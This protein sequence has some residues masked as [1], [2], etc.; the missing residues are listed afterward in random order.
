MTERTE[1]EQV[2]ADSQAALAK[3]TIVYPATILV[4]RD[5]PGIGVTATPTGDRVKL[6]TAQVRTLYDAYV[7]LDYIKRHAT[8]GSQTLADHT[9]Q[10]FA[11]VLPLYPVEW[12]DPK[13]KKLK[14]K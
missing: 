3:Q 5:R 12:A 2:T 6:S 8:D 14:P 10:Q 7:L 1:D 9:T 4:R 13:P 11:E